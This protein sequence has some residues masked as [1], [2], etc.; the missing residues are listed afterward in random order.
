MNAKNF[1]EMKDTTLNVIKCEKN[2]FYRWRKYLVLSIILL[3]S[4]IIYLE[5]FELNENKVYLLNL[6]FFHFI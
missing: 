5:Y 3:I 2:R 4:K 6:K 1:D